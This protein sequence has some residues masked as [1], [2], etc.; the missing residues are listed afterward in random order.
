MATTVK[1]D[2]DFTDRVIPGS[3]LEDA[4]DWIGA[5]M[6]PDDVFDQKSLDAWALANGY[7]EES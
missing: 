2:K 3:L 4:I 7:V 6:N 5:N 1:Q